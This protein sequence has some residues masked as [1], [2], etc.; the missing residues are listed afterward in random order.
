MTAI[1]ISIHATPAGGD[2]F[3]KVSH[4]AFLIFLST[5]PPRVATGHKVVIFLLVLI[6]IHAT[7]AGGDKPCLLPCPTATYF[8]PRHPRGWRRLPLRPRAQR[9]RI[10]IHATPAGGDF[11]AL[12]VLHTLNIFLSTPPPRVATKVAGQRVQVVR[13]SIHATPAG[14]DPRCGM[15][16]CW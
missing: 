2:W 4:S 12:T 5:P 16:A 11:L 3:S 15:L 7:P 8:Y 1:V 9:D 13:I 10:S 14:G 6:S